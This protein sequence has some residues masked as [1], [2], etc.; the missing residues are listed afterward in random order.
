MKITEQG[1]HAIETFIG[2]VAKK[3]EG[4]ARDVVM[5]QMRMLSESAIAVA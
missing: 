4:R 3:L 2:E 5:V 1:M